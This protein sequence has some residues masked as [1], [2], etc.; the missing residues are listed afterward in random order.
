MQ[1]SI[2]K[3]STSKR[4]ITKHTIRKTKQKMNCKLILTYKR[5]LLIRYIYL[6]KAI[7]ITV[8]A[9]TLGVTTDKHLL[10]YIFER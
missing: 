9:D 1:Y 3:Y 4:N 8:R 10:Q 2:Y 5:I 7:Q 6:F